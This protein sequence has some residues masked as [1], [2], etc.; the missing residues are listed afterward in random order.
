VSE[1]PPTAAVVASQTG[2]DLSDAALLRPRPV[3]RTLKRL[4][5]IL[6]SVVGLVLTSPFLLVAA[7]LVK[8]TSE[9]PVLFKQERMGRDFRPF[10]I[11]KFR[12]MVVNAP[13]L[14]GQITAGS[15]DPRITRVGAFLRKSK[16]DEL[17]QFINVLRGDMSL[18]GPRPEVPRY[19]E[20]FRDDYRV[21]LSIRPGIT[22][23]A[24]IKFRDEAAVLEASGDPEKYYAETLLP[25]KIQLG[26]QYIATSSLW[27]D[28]VIMLAT[29]FKIVKV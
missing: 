29:V 13:Q 1:V 3:Y 9:G 25:E 23:I 20:L 19:V 28:F 7:L 18:V 14:G 26:K 8:L 12:T 22:D 2:L 24:S 17:P 6:V 4:M 15:R 10:R 16:I 5:D 27:Q 21:L 11:L